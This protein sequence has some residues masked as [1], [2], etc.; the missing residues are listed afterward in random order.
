V[1]GAGRSGV[2]VVA[3]V[4]GAAGELDVDVRL[5]GGAAGLV[6]DGAVGCGVVAGAGALVRGVPQE[7]STTARPAAATAARRIMRHRHG[8]RRA[9]RHRD[10]WR[11]AAGSF[12]IV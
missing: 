5:G 12:R 8:W 9:C 2:V 7:A 4:G 1:D 6:D 10:L 3:T 11:T